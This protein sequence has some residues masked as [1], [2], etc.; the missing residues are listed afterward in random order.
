MNERRAI[1]SRPITAT[2]LLLFVFAG[3]T[4]AQDRASFT[5]RTASAARGQKAPGTIEAP[6]GSDAAFSIPVEAFAGS[7][8]GRALAVSARPHGPPDP[9]VIRAP[10]LLI[11]L[12]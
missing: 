4:A 6:P 10:E 2:A 7:K 1:M 12:N 5:V 9:S 8:L 11:N 3:L